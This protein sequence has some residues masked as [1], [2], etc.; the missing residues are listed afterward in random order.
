MKLNF[1]LNRG[2]KKGKY[3][4]QRKFD[5]DFMSLFVPWY[6]V[7]Q[8]RGNIAIIINGRQLILKKMPK[9]QDYFIDKNLGMFEINPD[10][11]FFLN[12]TAVYF[13]DVRN[14]NA[15]HP[16]LLDELYKWANLN[17][18][19]KIRRVDIEHAKKLRNI[20]PDQ[21]KE[22]AEREK[23]ANRK[24][25]TEVLAGIK[26][27]NETTEQTREKEGGD[28]NAEEYH[29][30]SEHESNYLIVKNLFDNGYITGHQQ[31]NLDHK[32]TIGTVKTT[33]DLLHE[34]DDFSTVYV[35]K[36]LSHELERIIDDFHTYK[37]RDIIGYIK[38]LS[39]IRK[40]IKMLR[41]KAV[42]NWFPS[43]YILF[44][45]LGIGVIYMLYAQYGG[46]LDLEGLIP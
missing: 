28:P 22:E 38:A 10:K 33:D 31:K 4:K 45:L 30:L 5:H 23:R 44:G 18:I 29:I 2:W 43:M 36:P 19:Y 11:S 9:N 32:L 39:K 16:G 8:F 42:I 37:P 12:K 6:E 20:Q 35:T 17:H 34:I 26:A 24:F 40:G 13:F 21:L 1:E 7:S 15:L 3:Y 25:M 41:T 14:Q 46:D 27:R